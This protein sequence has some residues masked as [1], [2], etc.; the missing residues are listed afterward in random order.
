MKL[1]GKL[2]ASIALSV[3]ALA[4][5]LFGLLQFVIALDAIAVD[6][7]NGHLGVSTFVGVIVTTALGVVGV[8]LAAGSILCIANLAGWRLSRKFASRPN[9]QS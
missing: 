9:N 2:A 8:G 7:A 1:I 5:V 4:S 6:S 3:F